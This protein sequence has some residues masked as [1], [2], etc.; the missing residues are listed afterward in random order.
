MVHPLA[1][2]QRVEETSVTARPHSRSALFFAIG[3]GAA[4]LLTAVAVLLMLSGEGL[5][6]DSTLIFTML[7]VSAVICREY[8]ESTGCWARIGDANSAQAKR[9]SGAVN[10]LAGIGRLGW[11]AAVR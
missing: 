6:G 3:F 10:C 1:A 7:G 4:A 2:D 9:A 5:A 8:A 11:G